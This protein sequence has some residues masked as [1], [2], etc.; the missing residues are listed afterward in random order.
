MIEIDLVFLQGTDNI[1]DVLTRIHANLSTHYPDLRDY[2]DSVYQVD[3]KDVG[4]MVY[5]TAVG[6]KDYRAMSLYFVNRD[7]EVSIVF[8]DLA[9]RYP[10]KT[11][12]PSIQSSLHLENLKRRPPGDHSVTLSRTGA[13][14]PV[15]P[16]RC[17]R[18]SP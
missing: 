9:S 18:S 14:G 4:E 11:H 7:K 2:Q 1:R 6:G 16:A 5:T 13:S 8:T 3:G 17:S 10:A 12:F 15:F